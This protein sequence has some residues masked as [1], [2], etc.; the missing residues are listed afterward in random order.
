MDVVKED[1][2]EAELDVLMEPFEMSG[3]VGR[4]PDGAVQILPAGVYLVMNGHVFN[5]D[6]VRKNRETGVF[7]PR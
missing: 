5:W 6:A 4:D 1:L 2:R 7:E 3:G